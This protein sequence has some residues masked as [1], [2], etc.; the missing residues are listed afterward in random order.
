MSNLFKNKVKLMYFAFGILIFVVM[1]ASLAYMTNYNHIH[2]WYSIDN[3]ALAINKTS[4]F[5]KT[6]SDNTNLYNFFESNITS[7]KI[8]DFK[9]VIYNF[10]VGMSNLNTFFITISV[11]GL[12]C[13]AALLICSNHNRRVYYKSNLVCGILAPLVTI[14]FNAIALV[15]NISMM[16]VFNNN[17]ELFNKVAILQNPENAASVTVSELNAASNVLDFVNS[18]GNPCNSITFIIFTILFAIVIIYSIVLIVFAVK[19]YKNTT[20]LRNEIIRR[21]VENNGQ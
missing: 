1:I 18:Q 16:G 11:I 21:A 7:V 5:S 2:V 17:Y 14:V 3:G 12:I 19:K 13:F 10:Q 9:Y 6:A 8:E 20:E 4:M 15:R